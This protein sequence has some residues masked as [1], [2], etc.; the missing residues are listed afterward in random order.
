M[1]KI[2]QDNDKLKNLSLIMQRLSLFIKEFILFEPKE[3]KQILEDIQN[4]KKLKQSYTV[5]EISSF[6]QIKNRIQIDNIRQ[7]EKALAYIFNHEC[8][9]RQKNIDIDDETEFT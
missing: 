5:S 4:H 3:E 9:D 2:I 7:T 6:D 1:C 8:E